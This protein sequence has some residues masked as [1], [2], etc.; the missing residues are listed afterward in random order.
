MK[1]VVNQRF[2]L[3]KDFVEMNMKTDCIVCCLIG[4]FHKK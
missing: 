2:D 3:K 4:V 1:K